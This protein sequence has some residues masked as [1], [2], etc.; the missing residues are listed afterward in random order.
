MKTDIIKECYNM[1]LDYVTENSCLFFYSLIKMKKP[2]KVLELG[3]GNGATA[4][5]IAFA[6]SEN[7]R[8]SITTIDNASA[9]KGKGSLEDHIVKYTKKWKLH[10]YLNFKKEDINLNNL[11][12]FKNVDIVTSDFLRT[13]D[14]VVSLIYWW[15]VNSNNYSSLFI[16]GLC[17]FYPGFSFV[18]ETINYFNKGV[19]PINFPYDTKNFINYKFIQINIRKTENDKL[20]NG[21]TWIKKE[22]YCIGQERLVL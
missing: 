19:V 11:T 2:K 17:D 18:T 12:N 14:Y 15:L 21:F 5:L 4:F 16:D 1:G 8:G 13:P 7:K 3:T 6:M 22:P 9:W 20:Q 10:N